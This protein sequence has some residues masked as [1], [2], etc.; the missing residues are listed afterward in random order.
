MRN[1]EEFAGDLIGSALRQGADLAEVFMTGGKALTVEIKDQAV[2]ALQSSLSSGYSLRVI[3][4]GRLGFAYATSSDLARS[5]AEDALSSA[6]HADADPHLALPVQGTSS[7]VDTF[8]PQA[9]SLEEEKAIRMVMELERAVYEEDKRITRVRKAMGSFSVS[10]TLVMNSLSVRASYEST[11]C[12][13]QVTAVAEQEGESQIG[14]DY[15][16]SRR[17]SDISFIDVGRR[18]SRRAVSLLGSRKIGGCKASVILDNSVTVDFL[19]IF[20]ASLSADTVQKGKSLLAGKSGQQ[21][22][23]P[24]I[25][26][27]DNG[28]IPWRSGSRPFDGEGV[29]TRET[30]L[31]RQGVLLAYLHN[32]Y[33]G[34]KAGVPSTGNAVRGGIASIPS[35]GVTNFFLASADGKVVSMDGLVEGT[36]RGLFV[37]DAMGVHTANPIS[38]DFSVG[39]TGLWIEGGAVQYPVREAVMSGN[40]LDL[41]SRVE[42]IG[43]DLTFYGSMGAP[44]LAISGVDISA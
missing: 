15:C 8:D 18:A 25:D 39:V 13:A 16:S 43:D 33:T 17:L 40:V 32:T 1:D 29:P 20:A 12:S 30:P 26:L 23:S 19:G 2:D 22:I 14:W 41:F 35:V 31:V 42:A 7:A 3:R 9:G 10:R 11:H 5:V 36:G 24:S 21:V 34:R 6:V 38:G 27:V 4:D 28:Q 37:M 44:S